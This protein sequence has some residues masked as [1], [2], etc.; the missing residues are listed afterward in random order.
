LATRARDPAKRCTRN[1]SPA[2]A[3]FA[4]RSALRDAGQL[5]Y[6]RTRRRATLDGTA[7]L[8][9]PS[10]T[11]SGKVF[12]LRGKGIKNVRGHVQGDLVCHVEMPVNFAHIRI[13]SY[14]QQVDF[15]CKI[16]HI[17]MKG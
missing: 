6:R 15:P 16:L 7:H 13:N 1:T 4:R 8:K 9:I 12:R 10:E 2:P 11:Q 14:R 3:R 17:E 5:H